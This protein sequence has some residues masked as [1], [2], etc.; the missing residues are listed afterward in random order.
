MTEKLIFLDI[1]V[2]IINLTLLLTGD[3]VGVSHNRYLGQKFI[4]YKD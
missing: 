4:N 1:Y 3:L 2:D